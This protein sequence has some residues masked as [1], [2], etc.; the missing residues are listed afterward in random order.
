MEN[1]KKKKLHQLFENLEIKY[2]KLKEK[3][4]TSTF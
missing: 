3:E 1:L 2:G 4:I